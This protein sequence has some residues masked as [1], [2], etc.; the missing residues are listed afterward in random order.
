MKTE[1][2]LQP[3]WIQELASS[4]FNEPMFT[5]EMKSSVLKNAANGSVRMGRKKRKS[6]TRLRM[7]TASVFM[8]LLIVAA[9]GWRESSV[10]QQLIPIKDWGNA[11]DWAP[12]SVYT[13]DGVDK[14]QAFPGG[15]YA[16]GSPAGAWWNLLTPIQDLEGKTIRISAV[17]RDTGITLEELAETKITSDMAYN[18]FTRVSSRFALP[19]SGLWR[20]DVMVDQEKYGDIV[21]DVPDSSWEPSPRFRSGNYAMTGVE[22]RLGFIHPGWFNAN[23]PNKYMWHFWGRDEELTGDLHITAVKRNTSEIIDVFKVAGLRPSPLNGADAAIPTSMSLPSPG[24]WRIM[25]SIDGQLFDSVIVEVD[26][27]QD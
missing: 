16:A 2:E 1:Q 20:F 4:P 25:V 24:L 18:D 21:V 11:A 12:R 14:L 7:M 17:H 13:E 8:L 19:L 3:D 26:K 10:I 23:Q 9:W 6:P 27:P 5:E 15:D 22:G